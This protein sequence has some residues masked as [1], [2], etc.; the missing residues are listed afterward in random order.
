MLGRYYDVIFPTNE[1][2]LMF[3]KALLPER[4]SVLDVGCATGTYAIPLARLGYDVCAFDLDSPMV[5]MLVSKTENDENP[6]KA[7]VY[8]M[9]R[10]PELNVGPFDLI[11]CIGNTLVHLGSLAEVNELVKACREKLKE[12][13]SVVIQTVNYDRVLA[14]KDLSLP[15]IDRQEGRMRFH[16]HY[17]L[18]DAEVVFH[19]QLEIEG[20]GKT[21]AST[22]LLPVEAGD[23]VRALEEA[24]F[25]EVNVYGGFDGS[26]HTLESPATVIVAGS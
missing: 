10:L 1:K 23:L 7:L 2:Q 8:D 22:T 15:L 9:R 14:H 17:E 24:G 21:E 3:L 13:G 18:K 25:R 11:Y 5:E 26:P 20:Q 12:S 19:G 16:R 4:G 6:P